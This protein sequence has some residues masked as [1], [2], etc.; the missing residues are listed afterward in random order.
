MVTMRNPRTMQEFWKVFTVVSG[1]NVGVAMLYACGV[2]DGAG[3]ARRGA[4]QVAGASIQIAGESLINSTERLVVVS[5]SVDAIIRAI[6]HIS[7][8]MIQVRS[9]VIARLCC[10]N[11]RSCARP[12]RVS[13]RLRVILLPYA[14]IAPNSS[15]GCSSRKTPKIF[16]SIFMEWIN[17]KVQFNGLIGE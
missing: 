9:D 4:V 11:A 15:T 7:D 3:R 8:V 1:N 2:I 12:S 6:F 14:L 13:R 10:C 16:F 5:G 17:F